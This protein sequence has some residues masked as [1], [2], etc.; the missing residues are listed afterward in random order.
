MSEQYKAIGL[1]ILPHSGV[2]VGIFKS[3]SF[4]SSQEP[5]ECIDGDR[6]LWVI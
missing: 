3:L 6:R 1:N 5:D 4:G 2:D